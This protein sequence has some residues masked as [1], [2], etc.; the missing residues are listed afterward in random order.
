VAVSAERVAGAAA[1]WLWYPDDATAV[2]TDDFLLVRWPDYV[3]SEPA[4]ARVAATAPVDEA[5]DRVSEQVRAWGFG[6]LLAWVKLDAPPALEEAL[7]SRGGR[8]HETVDV[9]A[10]DLAD[11]MPDLGVPADVEVRWQVDEATTRDHW[12]VATAAFGEGRM[13]GGDDVRRMAEEAAA[14]H[15]EGRGG[16]AIG[17]LDGR[18][19]GSGGLTTAG[20][21]VRL[22][23][24]GVVPSARGRGV[25]R[26]V[27]ATRL[28]YAVERG[29]TMAIVK[30]RVETSG[31]ILRRVGFTAYGQE[32]CYEV[33]VRATG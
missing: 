24:G 7:V 22:W 13:P 28:A 10:L 32:R 11:G 15:R 26:A 5:L 27:L 16:C 33:P 23:S 12:S 20:D 6:S 17:Y 3:G 14:D 8:L 4:L 2:R 9:C 30:G 31:P 1:A 18:P 29:A 21:V 25:Y 19:V